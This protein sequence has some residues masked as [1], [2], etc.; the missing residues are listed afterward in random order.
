MQAD[1]LLA[2]LPGKPVYIFVSIIGYCKICAIGRSLL[3]ICFICSHVYLLI[4]SSFIPLPDVSSLRV[5]CDRYVTFMLRAKH[6]STPS[7]PPAHGKH[8][9]TPLV[10][11]LSVW[12]SSWA[13]GCELG[14]PQVVA[15]VIR[16][17]TRSLCPPRCRWRSGR[18]SRRMSACW[19]STRSLSWPSTWPSWT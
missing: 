17:P 3:F 11:R 19:T 15:L 14:V 18:R 16:R 8:V 4:P 6:R 13:S 1:S 2:E 5:G 7:R 9:N 12:R 10:G